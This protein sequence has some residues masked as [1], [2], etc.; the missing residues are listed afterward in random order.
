MMKITHSIDSGSHNLAA[1][2]TISI[3]VNGHIPVL[4]PT[5]PPRILND[6]VPQTSIT[7]QHN[8]VIYTVV[9]IALVQT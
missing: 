9:R 8:S 2:L 7:H 5:L 3:P 6:P 1:Y 4:T